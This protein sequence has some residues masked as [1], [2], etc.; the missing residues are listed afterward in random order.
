MLESLLEAVL[1]ADYSTQA[2]SIWIWKCRTG[3]ATVCDRVMRRGKVESGGD[4][5][6]TMAAL[7]KADIRFQR[8]VLEQHIGRVGKQPTRCCG[9]TGGSYADIVL[10]G[11]CYENYIALFWVSRSTTPSKSAAV[12]SLL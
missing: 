12:T 6:P 2:K 1:I 11:H 5:L 3:R 9:S 7:V 8:G 4:G 10:R